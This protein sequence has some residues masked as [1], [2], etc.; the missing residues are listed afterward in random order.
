[1][2]QLQGEHE[3]ILAGMRLLLGCVAAAALAVG[4]AGDDAENPVIY[5]MRHGENVSAGSS[6]YH[7]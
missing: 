3:D 7:R 1:M 2:V 4:A 6:G 5:L